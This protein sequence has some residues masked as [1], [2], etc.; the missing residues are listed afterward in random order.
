MTEEHAYATPKEA[1]AAA[2]EI[3][4]TYHATIRDIPEEWF[5][6]GCQDTTFLHAYRV[7]DYNIEPVLKDETNEYGSI[8]DK[9]N[10]PCLPS[11]VQHLSFKVTKWG[12]GKS[13]QAEAQQL[14]NALSEKE[15]RYVK[16]PAHYR[17]Y[18][19]RKTENHHLSEA[20][21]S[22][23]FDARGKMRPYLPDLIYK[24]CAQK[25]EQSDSDKSP[26]QRGRDIAKS[27]VAAGCEVADITDTFNRL[28]PYVVKPS[29]SAKEDDGY[30]DTDTDTICYYPGHAMGIACDGVER[31]AVEEVF[32]RQ[33]LQQEQKLEPNVIHAMQEAMTDKNRTAIYNKAMSCPGCINPPYL[34]HSFC[35]R[36]A[37]NLRHRMAYKKA[38]REGREGESR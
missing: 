27:M 30:T 8:H 37:S 12:I 33:Y 25:I 7:G 26:L 20:E 18:M 16:F 19:K 38:L 1:E 23:L 31:Y 13:R 32:F 10:T 11:A 28:S 14:A 2:D 29:P 24:Y 6:K 4:Q 15:I 5:E 22:K 9:G 3:A 21:Q 17:E 34:E 35:K 36:L